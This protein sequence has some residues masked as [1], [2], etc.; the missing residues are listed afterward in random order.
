MALLH[1]HVP[2]K[3]NDWAPQFSLFSRALFCSSVTLGHSTVALTKNWCQPLGLPERRDKN[4]INQWWAISRQTPQDSVLVSV[5]FPEHLWQS[6]N[7]EQSLFDEKPIHLIVT[8]WLRLGSWGQR[9]GREERKRKGRYTEVPQSPSSTYPQWLKD[10]KLSPIF[11]KCA[12]PLDITKLTNEVFD[13]WVFL[14]YYRL[15][16]QPGLVINS[17]TVSGP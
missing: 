17:S 2:N 16:A 6:G 9:W 13:T 10:H 12:P 15:T 11:Q 4:L 8:T 14:E 3:S 5:P 1:E 7:R